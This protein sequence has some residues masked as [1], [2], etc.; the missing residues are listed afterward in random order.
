MP[1]KMKFVAENILEDVVVNMIWHHGAGNAL[2][3]KM[4]KNI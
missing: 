1:N 4:F 2:V 3:C